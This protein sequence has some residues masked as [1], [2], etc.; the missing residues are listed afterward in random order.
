MQIKTVLILSF[1]LCGGCSSFNHYTIAAGEKENT[2]WSET[3]PT[4]PAYTEPVC[5]DAKFSTVPVLPPPPLKRLKSVSPGDDE[6]LDNIELDYIRQLTQ[7]GEAVRKKVNDEHQK[8]REACQHFQD[9]QRDAT[10]R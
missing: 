2:H 7:Y 5:P 3:Q 8:Y 6:A 9:A 10:E 4:K 1:A